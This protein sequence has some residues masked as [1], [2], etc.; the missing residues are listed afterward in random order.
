VT[1]VFSPDGDAR[2]TLKASR[3]ATRNAVNHE[4][5]EVAGNGPKRV[6]LSLS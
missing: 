3:A 6:M 1:Q 5:R 2:A 4:S